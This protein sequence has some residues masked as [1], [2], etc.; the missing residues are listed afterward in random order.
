M[1]RT[2][3]TTMLFIFGSLLQGSVL[4]QETPQEVA[5]ETPDISLF[6]QVMLANPEEA[7]VTL[8]KISKNWKNGYA[9]MLIELIFQMNPGCC[10][11]VVTLPPLEKLQKRG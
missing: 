6:F 10:H 3:V 4:S 2:I 9:S 7:E 11:L 8:E 5:N 1:K